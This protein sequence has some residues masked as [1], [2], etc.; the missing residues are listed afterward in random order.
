MASHRS[1][2]TTEEKAFLTTAVLGHHEALWNRPT[3]GQDLAF[4]TRW[5]LVT[6]H[7]AE[8]GRHRL[9]YQ[10]KMVRRMLTEMGIPDPDM[11]YH[12]D[13]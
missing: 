11:R 7:P 9:T 1:T 5:H 12:F 6:R 10:G 13:D 8:D 2:L 4:L 3:P